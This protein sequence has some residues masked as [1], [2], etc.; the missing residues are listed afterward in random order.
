MI[1]DFKSKI[2]QNQSKLINTNHPSG[3]FKVP[4]N[5][6]IT[7]K[8]D[9]T[10]YTIRASRSQDA[11][12]INLGDNNYQ[13]NDIASGEPNHISLADDTVTCLKG[14]L[15]EVNEA[16]IITSNNKESSKL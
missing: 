10:S 2:S 16:I 15:R 12:K 7:A 8:L 13:F 14:Y 4:I 9:K 1:L 11:D 3:T 5:I 6:F